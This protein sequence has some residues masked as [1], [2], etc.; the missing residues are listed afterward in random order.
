MN[1]SEAAVAIRRV[2]LGNCSH[3]AQARVTMVGVSLRELACR[4]EA[5]THGGAC[6]MRRLSELGEL[7]ELLVAAWA[8]GHRHHDIVRRRIDVCVERGATVLRC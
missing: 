3:L 7:P 5:K 6:G 8:W 2:T 4:R 1:R